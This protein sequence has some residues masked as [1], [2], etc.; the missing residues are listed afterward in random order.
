MSVDIEIRIQYWPNDVT[1]RIDFLRTHNF[2]LLQ[3][4]NE[5]DLLELCLK[6]I[7]EENAQDTYRK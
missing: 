3:A 4:K 7:M 6:H 2:K 1:A 5:K